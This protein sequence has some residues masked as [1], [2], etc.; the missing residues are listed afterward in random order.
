MTLAKFIARKLTPNE[1]NA[2]IEGLLDDFRYLPG[3][4]KIILFGSAAFGQMSEASDLDVVLIFDSPDE[5]R[6]ASR[7]VYK[8][9]KNS[10]WPADILC[11]D[12][13]SYEQRSQMGGVLFVAR[14]EG[15][16]I[17]TRDSNVAVS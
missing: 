6:N 12:T 10:H 15:R 17:F 5:A 16:V 4:K 11:A 14:Q 1:V 3:L 2:E 7:K 13:A 8:I 9:R